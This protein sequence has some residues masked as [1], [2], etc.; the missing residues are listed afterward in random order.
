MLALCAT[1]DEA[2]AVRRV[3]PDAK[4]L[5]GPAATVAEFKANVSKARFLHIGGF[6]AAPGGGFRLADG[7][8]SLGDIAA[9]PIGARAAVL[10]GGAGEGLPAD[11]LLARMAALHRAGGQDVLVEGWTHDPALRSS[12]L[13]HFWEGA[14]RSYSAS[15]ALGEARTLALRESGQESVGA[16][17]W[18]GFF[19]SGRP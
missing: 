17:A 12:M 5:E 3:Y 1:A 4:V 15:R 19:A 13:F 11:V 7:V 8:L 10:L 6:P 2:E 16:A 18:G 9:Q 14:N